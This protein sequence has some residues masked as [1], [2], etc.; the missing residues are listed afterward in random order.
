MHSIICHV[1]LSRSN[2]GQN[3]TQQHKTH[4]L[5]PAVCIYIYSPHFSCTLST[6]EHTK[7]VH[8]Q[9]GYQTLSNSAE[10]PVFERKNLNNEIWD[11]WV[12]LGATWSHGRCP[13]PCWNKVVFEVPSNPNPF[14]TLHTGSRYSFERNEMTNTFSSQHPSDKGD[15]LIIC[16]EEMGLKWVK[17]SGSGRCCSKELGALGNEFSVPV[18]NPGKH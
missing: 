16:F 3:L 13:C 7:T 14:V 10:M 12:G 11:G 1:W 17:H 6:E 9:R 5:T 8:A 2:S 18:R 4:Q 15:F